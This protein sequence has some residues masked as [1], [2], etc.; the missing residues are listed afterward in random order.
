MIKNTKSYFY[1]DEVDINLNIELESFLS[2]QALLGQTTNQVA[3]QV[4]R[5]NQSALSFLSS[6]ALLG[7]TTRVVEQVTKLTKYLSP[8]FP[9]RPSWLRPTIRWEEQVN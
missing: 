1:R 2:S 8:F 4:N 7:Y 9:A 5:I 6:Q 3:E